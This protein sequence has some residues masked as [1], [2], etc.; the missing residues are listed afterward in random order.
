M[1]KHFGWW[2][3]LA[4]VTLSDTGGGATTWVQDGFRCVQANR[5]G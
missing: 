3:D 4:K 1:D 2:V 5:A